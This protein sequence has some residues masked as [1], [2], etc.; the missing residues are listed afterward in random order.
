MPAINV[1]RTDTFEQQRVKI[2][3]I[4]TQI[5]NVTAGGSDLATGNLKIGDGTKSAP[6]LAFE[7]EVGLG[8]YRPNNSVIG[9]VSDNKK[10]MNV[11]KASFVSFRDFALQKD[12]VGQLVIDNPGNN[13]D[14]GNYSNIPLNGGTGENFTCDILVT[15]HTGTILEDGEGYITGQYNQVGLLGGNGSGAVAGFDVEDIAGT[16]TDAGSGYNP[17]N[18]QGV[19]VLSST[20]NGQNATANVTVQGTVLIAGNISNA[21]SGYDQNTYTSVNLF[22]VPVDTKVVTSVT[23][24]GTPPPNE[25]YSIDGNV[26][27][28]LTLIRGNTY[29]FDISDG[30][31]LGHPLVF[32]QTDGSIL[33]P[34]LYTVQQ[35][36]VGGSSGAF[37]DFIIDAA[38]PTGNIKYNC[39]AHDGM[40]A[41]ISIVNG[42]VGNYGFGAQADVEVNSSG[43]VSDFT[44]VSNGTNY[45]Q[46]DTLTLSPNDIGSGGS[47]FVY[48][49][50]AFTYNG[51]VQNISFVTQGSGYE[52]GDVLTVATADL[53]NVG[54]S[55]FEFTIS[56]NPSSITNF[57]WTDKGTG[58]SV[59]DVLTLPRAVTGVTGTLNGEV[60]GVSTTLSTATAIIAVADASGISSGM[61]V[62]AEAGSTGSIAPATTVSSVSGNN[63]TL[64]ANPD[65][66]GAASLRFASP[67]PFDQ[68]VVSTVTGLSTGMIV[69]VTSGTGTLP[70]G[71]TISNIDASTLT[72]TLSEQSTF[73]G[74]VV[75]EFQPEFGDPA[76]DWEYRV[77]VLGPIENAVI[78]NPGNGY[79]T[80]DELTVQN[81]ELVQPI[82]I[83]V[84]NAT[85]QKV[86]FSS[87]LSAG[88]ITTADKVSDVND[89]IN[90][91]QVADVK[92]AGGNISYILVE[93]VSLQAG[94]Q[95]TKEGSSTQYAVDTVAAGYRYAL[96]GD[97]TPSITLYVGNTYRFDLSD[98]SNTSHNFALSKF[99]DGK[100]GPSKIENVSGNTTQG[101]NVITVTS[102]TGISAGMTVLVTTGTGLQLQNL[103][104]DEVIDGTSLR[105]SSTATVTNA[106]VATFTGTEYTTS[107]E[108]GSDYL[109]ITIRPD[110]P[111]LYYYCD[112]S[113]TGHENEGGFDN[114]EIAL[115][116]NANNPK[117]FGS[118]ALFVVGQ[119]TT[120]NSFFADIESGKLTIVDLESPDGTITDL[121]STDITATNITA[122]T[123]LNTPRIDNG[124]GQ[125]LITSGSLKING[126]INNADKLSI[127]AATGDLTTP[128]NIK[129]TA[130]F[131]VN[132][133][134]RIQN[135]VIST[136]ASNA[137]IELTPFSGRVAKVN[138]NSAIIIPTGNTTERPTALAQDGAIRFNTTTGQYEG[139][140]SSTTSWASLGGVRDL[141]G[142]TYIKAEE[143]VGANDN[144]L[145]F[146]ND[147][148]V[149]FKFN[150]TRL[151]FESAKK[152]YSANTSAPAYVDYTTNTTVSVGDY[153]KYKNNLYEV[154]Q[155]GVTG[156]GGNE[157]T[158]TTGT[159][160]NGTTQLL[161]WGLAVGKLTLEDIEQL[162]IGP[163]STLPVSINSDLRLE[164]NVVSTDIS[165][166]TLRPNSG[167]KIVCDGT[168]TLALPS[169]PDSGRGVPIQGSV[170][171]STTTSQFEGYDGAN[172][173]SLGGVKD[174]DQNTYIIPETAPGQ[175]ENIL[176]FYNDG[177]NSL[178][179]TTSALDF[180]SVDT[181]RSM[182]SDEFEIT[183]SMMTIDNAATTIDNTDVNKSFLYSTKNFFDIGMSSGVR[184]DPIFR[185]DNTGDVYFNTGFGTGTYNGVK[186]FDNEFKEF[187][188]LQTRIRTDKFSLVKGTLDSN[189]TLIYTVT[190]EEGSKTTICAHNTST[191]E[192]EFIEFGIIDDGTDVVHTEYGNISTGSDII[193][194]TFELTPANEVRV[195]VALTA[196]V[197]ATHTVN[198]TIVSH[199]TKK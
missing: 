122:S 77:D 142:N 198:I 148:T 160:P 1:A 85:Y 118:G 104:V 170:R 193:T 14:P 147:N 127:T 90:F 95:I 144:N 159:Q 45:Q 3:Q 98:N 124:T 71:A 47:G 168:T 178:Q 91:Y 162:D 186:V 116:V 54:G 167:K 133:Q 119:I 177:N 33:D 143:S 92:L 30:S 9:Y 101:S 19:A 86:T 22:N 97:I 58:Y 25:V 135:N 29:R 120:S 84:T 49:L 39:S 152:V 123:R 38:A 73:P 183:A 164:N 88:T 151:S 89:G 166:L 108:R 109:D 100:Y 40:G 173:G 158:H 63:I 141:D 75:L 117:T 188:L 175:N 46:G 190:V 180:Y 69:S 20:G 48:T 191:N 27:Q 60:S 128:G 53:G 107:V 6:S 87:P 56:N 121:T 184:I 139:Y 83:V 81:T 8:I 93:G 105:L 155:A 145:W 150:K 16:I 21:G 52:T 130:Y 140:N 163:T 114:E 51:V 12:V 80:L 99:P 68:V 94:G 41:A 196:N 195:D 146:I 78:N 76:T 149:S 59:N 24:P 154:T 50:G 18:Y 43:V 65:G 35:S 4:S 57:Q 70:T 187:E 153:L 110:T 67:D 11:S 74:D 55:G 113:A 111:N 132:D 31:M 103:L 176:Y 137:D 7:N 131:N 112:V 17:G 161:W 174:V 102:T 34:S 165:D 62:F 10:L 28:T 37:V 26:Q 126:D 185:L 5:F 129:T 66:D 171:F 138:S 42:T 179:L 82:S 96:D 23:N 172:W 106:I 64:S 157:P 199:V 169:G 72:L 2:N 125:V 181:I 79:E 194:P 13:Y 156:T 189:N 115:V 44:L 134:L 36:G 15:A 197:T 192:K 136:T 32:Q 182:T 61:T